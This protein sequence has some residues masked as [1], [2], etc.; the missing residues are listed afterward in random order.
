[1]R[2]KKPKLYHL[3]AIGTALSALSALPAAA[4]AD[5]PNAVASIKPIHS[6]VAG[7][8]EGVG[9]PKLI[10][11]G[12]SSPHTYNMR[13]SDASAVAH[14]SV[15]FWV[16]KPLEHFLEKPISSLGKN[17]LSV[18]LIDAPGVKTLKPRVG[19]TFDPDRDGDAEDGHS[20][21]VDP[22]FWLDPENAR[23]AVKE[24]AATLEKLDPPHAK[25]YAANAEKMDTDLKNLETKV[26]AE[27]APVKDRPFIVFHDAYH[28]FEARF[29]VTAAGSVTISPDVQPGAARI[30]EM[31]DKVRSLGAVCIFS[32]PEFEPKLVDT[33][34]GGTNAH[35]SV[36]DPIG[37]DMTEGPGLYDKLLTGLADNLKNCLSQ[38]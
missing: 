33:I 27:I 28:Y 36:L 4:Y 13:P 17:A 20:D 5:G 9:T 6:L 8:M 37:G 15:V 12:A 19:G 38:E 11:Q 16:G 25:T 24:I 30:A 31:E 29:G 23:A 32:E 14:A 26:A 34:A 18:E 7:V 2:F 3:L 35:K 1:M 21:A 22:H 10:V